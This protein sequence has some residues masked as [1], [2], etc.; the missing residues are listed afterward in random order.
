MPQSQAVPP[1]WPTRIGYAE[2]GTERKTVRPWL[3]LGRAPLWKQPSG[4]SMLNPFVD[5][6]EDEPALGAAI[7]WAKQLNAVLRRQMMPISMSFSPRPMAPCSRGSHT[8][9]FHAGT[10]QAA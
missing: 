6:L 7:A 10:Y 2:L 4:D 9:R 1:R 3:R 5:L 8:T